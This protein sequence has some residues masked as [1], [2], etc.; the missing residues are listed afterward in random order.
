MC[1]GGGGVG[2]GRV[3]SC[4]KSITRGPNRGLKLTNQ[5]LFVNKGQFVLVSISLA[6]LINNW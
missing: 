4:I 3:P 5:S 6:E 1:G 2:G